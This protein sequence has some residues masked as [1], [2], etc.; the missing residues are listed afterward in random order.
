MRFVGSTFN[1]QTFKFQ[2]LWNEMN[3]VDD[4]NE[5]LETR[6]SGDDGVWTK[7]R[8]MEEAKLYL[9]GN[10]QFSEFKDL[11]TPEEEYINPVSNFDDIESGHGIGTGNSLEKVVTVLNGS[12]FLYIPK[13]CLILILSELI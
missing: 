5:A 13:A 4:N 3:G 10:K 11:S 8:I 7:E 6:T 12:F 9:S 2:D 1:N